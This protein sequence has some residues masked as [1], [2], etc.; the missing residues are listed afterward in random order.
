MNRFNQITDQQYVPLP[1][2]EI[3]AAGAMADKRADNNLAAINTDLAASDKLGAI[4]GTKD[5][6]YIQGVQKQMGEL[7]NKYSTDP[8]L[9]SNP[10]AYYNFR[11]EARAIGNPLLI[12]NIQQ[13][14]D[15]YQKDIENQQKL[16]SDDKLNS[17]LIPSAI[18]YS[19]E[20]NGIYNKFTPSL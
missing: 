20:E 6:T 8:K 12:S 11:R 17:G 10:S 7:V 2:K 13:S 3:M 15:N 14:K 5:Q 19:T 18:N 9:Y 16:S 4:P 1:F